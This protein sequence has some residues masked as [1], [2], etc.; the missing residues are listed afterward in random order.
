MEKVAAASIGY[1]T[2]SSAAY[3]PIEA[4]MACTCHAA[5]GITLV[6]GRQCI[7]DLDP[8]CTAY[9]VVT[10]EKPVHRGS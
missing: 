5:G 2:L 8:E 1:I 9:E 4:S 10:A 7:K 6:H 3:A